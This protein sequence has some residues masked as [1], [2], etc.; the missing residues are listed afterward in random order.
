[1]GTIEVVSPLSGTGLNN[2]TVSWES[3][4]FNSG[5]PPDVT[6]TPTPLP[7]T[8]TP[9]PTPE[10]IPHLGLLADVHTGNEACDIH[11]LNS[12]NVTTQYFTYSMGTNLCDSNRVEFTG[13][14]IT[15]LGNPTNYQPI[16]V[17]DGTYYR[18]GT[19]DATGVSFSGS[20]SCVLCGS[21]T[22][23]PTPT[24]TGTTIPTSTPTSTPTPTPP[25]LSMGFSSAYE[26]CDNLNTY[27]NILGG[28]NFLSG[29][30]LCDSTGF[31]LSTYDAN[32]F[33]GDG[34][35]WFSDGTNSRAGTKTGGIFMFT[36]ACESCSSAVPPTPTPTPT[37]TPTVTP[38][39][40][41]AYQGCISSTTFNQYDACQSQIVDYT[42][43]TA[44]PSLN[45]GD[46]L[47]TDSS[48]T[49]TYVT[50]F[51]N[52]F[53]IEDGLDKYVIDT[54]IGGQ[55][56]T[57][58]NCLDISGP[59]P[60]PT[61]T[62][63]P[64]TCVTEVS[65]DVVGAGQ[66][67]YLDCCG[68]GKYITF[69]ATGPE[70]INDC[71]QH[72]TL[73]GMSATIEFINYGITS[74]DCVTS[75]PTPA[76]TDTPT[77][78]PV[79]NAPTDTP[80]PT[81]VPNAPTDTPT[82]TPTSTP[83]PTCYLYVVSADDGTSNRDPYNFYYT[84]CDGTPA[85]GS[86]VNNGPSITVCA[87][88]GSVYGD[89]P[90]NISEEG[91]ICGS[92][93]TQ[94][95][96]NVPTLEPTNVPTNVPT[97]TPPP[98]AEPTATPEPTLHPTVTPAP[99]PPTDTPTPE[100]PPPTLPPTATPVPT[101]TPT[102]TPLPDGVL[103]FGSYDNSQQPC[104][105][106][107]GPNDYEYYR[108]YQVDFTSPRSMNGYVVVY[109][110]DST[111]ISLSFNQNDTAASTSVFCGC[112][113]PCADMIG[114]S[115]ILYTTSTPTPEPLLPTEPPVECWSAQGSG[116]IYNSYAECEL[117]ESGNGFGPCVQVS[118]P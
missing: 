52:Y 59:T 87:R 72:G 73:M 56:S 94:V 45:F 6:P 31:E 25:T 17:S 44:N 43:Y 13:V 47:F 98:T 1:M 103:S 112:G 81:P 114:V 48:L 30:T 9:T 53:I 41:Y 33:F 77:P 109:L 28:G 32:T 10:P 89:G 14:D 84:R 83:I 91:A 42:F 67:S 101:D 85:S 54:T 34:S 39:Q 118:C 74:C 75:T 80:T 27:I 51:G 116:T 79:P 96:T 3:F 8:S 16:W 61:P 19:L 82:P 62:D 57:L 97:V 60:T 104:G 63:V 88:E 86:R 46:V 36:N 11:T 2:Y 99:P 69:G 111:T 92:D 24:M 110:S 90:I 105:Y 20:D 70:V 100:P 37:A 35:G 66:V 115:N 40:S 29:S 71:I 107:F 65:F 15:N 108:T 38:V 22:P 5:L 55:I 49:N 7:A 12:Y 64:P 68:V 23:T 58:V 93:P 4:G 21:A 78:T 18:L 106:G 50:G 95:P 26:T 117:G 102:P 76:P 113:S